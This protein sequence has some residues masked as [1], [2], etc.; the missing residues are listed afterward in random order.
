[1]NLVI[2]QVRGEY[3]D[4]CYVDE[5]AKKHTLKSSPRNDVIG[6]HFCKGNK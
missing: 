1:M 4:K 5:N 3:K 2:F 6:F